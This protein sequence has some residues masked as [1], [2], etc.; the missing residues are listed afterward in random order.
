M[1]TITT[2]LGHELASAEYASRRRVEGVPAHQRF[3]GLSVSQLQLLKTPAN[4]RLKSVTNYQ[5]SLKCLPY[6][7]L[8]SPILAARVL[9]HFAF[10]FLFA[11]LLSADNVVSAMNFSANAIGRTSNHE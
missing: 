5:I 4:A 6:C 1:E 9:L 2:K 11:L 8:F 10:H 3:L 7:L